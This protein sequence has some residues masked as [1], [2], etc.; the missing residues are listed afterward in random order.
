MAVTYT[1]TTRIAGSPQEA[2]V[3]AAE[4]TNYIKENHNDTMRCLSRVGGPQGEIV[5]ASSVADL[6]ALQEQ[7]QKIQ[8]D[9]GYME[10]VNNAISGGLINTTSTET[11]IWLDLA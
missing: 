1:V 6:A 5:F 7:L 10:R 3:W 2:L 8:D 11:A 9:S 4:M